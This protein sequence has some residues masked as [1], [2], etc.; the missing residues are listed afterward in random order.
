MTLTS[1]KI[2]QKLMKILYKAIMM[3]LMKHIFLKLMFN[4]LKILIIFDVGKLVTSLHDK[5]E[6]VIHIRNLKHA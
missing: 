4:I 3:K 5:G 6:Y 1:L 2:F